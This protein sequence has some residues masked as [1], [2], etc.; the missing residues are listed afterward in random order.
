MPS[1]AVNV[2]L[3]SFL[4]QLDQTI[5]K[6]HEAFRV[7]RAAQQGGVRRL[8]SAPQQ[9]REKSLIGKRMNFGDSSSSPVCSEGCG[10]NSQASC[11]SLRSRQ[12]FV[13]ADSPAV[14]C[15]WDSLHETQFDGVLDFREAEWWTRTQTSSSRLLGSAR[16]QTLGVDSRFGFN[17]ADL[18]AEPGGD[19][20]GVLAFIHILCKRSAVELFPQ[21]RPLTFTFPKLLARFLICGSWEESAVE[22]QEQGKHL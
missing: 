12:P 7:G 11:R 5:Q 21:R 10:T 18:R 15:P 3:T 4:D 1:S 9:Y 20:L 22:A 13:A 6:F 16:P 8:A 17:D 2:E 19:E 14:C